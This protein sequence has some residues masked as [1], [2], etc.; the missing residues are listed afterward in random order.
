MVKIVWLFF[1][2]L[3]FIFDISLYQNT[4]LKSA[5]PF[6]KIANM[7]IAPYVFW[8]PWSRILSKSTRYTSISI[9]GI[10]TKKS[11]TFFFSFEPIKFLFLLSSYVYMLLFERSFSIFI[12]RTVTYDNF[13]L[14]F[15]SRLYTSNSLFMFT[16]FLSLSLS[17]FM[18]TDTHTRAR[19]R[20]RTQTRTPKRSSSILRYQIWVFFH[21]EFFMP[22]VNEDKKNVPPGLMP[23]GGEIDTIYHTPYPYATV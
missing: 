5:K 14:L 12:L 20:T 10:L 17:L 15:F 2:G 23:F 16:S 19:A 13:P 8:P 3:C 22:F 9:H 6:L 21:A 7:Q 4:A 18:H 11:V 1:R